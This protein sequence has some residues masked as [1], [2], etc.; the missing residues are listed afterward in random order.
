L[1]KNTFIESSFSSSTDTD[2]IGEAYQKFNYP[3][4]NNDDTV[5]CITSKVPIKSIETSFYIH[6]QI[7]D[8]E[9][10][11]L[12]KLLRITNDTITLCVKM[13][14][15]VFQTLLTKSNID[16]IYWD[17]NK[18]V[19]KYKYEKEPTLLKH[20]IKHTTN[21]PLLLP[22]SQY[23]YY[24]DDDIYCDEDYT[25][26]NHKIILSDIECLILGSAGVGKTDLIKKC[27]SY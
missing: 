18:T 5:V 16:N 8:L 2:K 6:S 13:N 1:L 19:L 20:E 7:L 3:Y 26:I 9:A 11:E 25:N 27:A 15:V 21:K 4:N 12:H 17:D 23:T 22:S 10:V 24:N 14:C